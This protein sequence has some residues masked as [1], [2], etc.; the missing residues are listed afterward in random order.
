[1]LCPRLRPTEAAAA[2][3]TDVQEQAPAQQAQQAQQ[4]GQRLQ[5]VDPSVRLYLEGLTEQLIATHIT[6]ASG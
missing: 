1:M 3:A 2:L 5:A 6:E 4:Q